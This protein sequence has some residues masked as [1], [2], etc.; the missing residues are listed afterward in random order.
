[1]IVFLVSL[2]LGLWT[3][4]TSSASLKLN[5]KKVLI[6][7]GGPSGLLTAHMLMAKS[8]ME[9]NPLYSVDIHEAG[10]SPADQLP[11]PR[12]YSLGLNI[13]GQTAVMYFDSKRSEG[14]FDRLKLEGVLSDSFFLHIGK[15]KFHIRK[16]SSAK[17]TG[18]DGDVAPPPTL[19]LPRNGLC[20]G[21]LEN[22]QQNYQ[23]PEDKAR[24]NIFYGSKVTAVDLTSN[25]ATVTPYTRDTRDTTESGTE[26]TERIEQ[27]SESHFDLIIGADGVSSAVRT[28][29]QEQTDLQVQ[30]AVLPGAFKVMTLPFPQDCSLDQSSVHALESTAK[31][32]AGFGLFLIPAPPNKAASNNTVCALLAWRKEEVPE[33]LKG[34]Q[35]EGAED[36]DTEKV[37]KAIHK[38]YPQLGYVPDEAIAQLA[39][40]RP[41]VAKTVRCSAYHSSTGNALI[42]GDAAHSTGGTLGQGANSA[43]L[44]VVALDRCLE[45]VEN[46]EKAGKGELR[47]G[48]SSALREFSETQ[49]KEGRA[50]WTLLQVQPKTLGLPW[51]PLYQL[52]QFKRSFLRLL[53]K[54]IVG[55][56]LFLL[57]SFGSRNLAEKA[58]NWQPAQAPTQQVLSQTL[59]PFSEIVRDNI[60]WVRKAM[61]KIGEPL[62]AM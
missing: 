38:D 11:G 7:G 37:R 55:N 35:L 52:A 53:Y 6:A 21:L 16:P 45:K 28:A 56:V 33:V 27:S 61:Q 1:M 42:L 18:K 50:L 54:N 30:E 58:R 32:R 34:A 20:L 19:L 2:F 23:Q 59:Q 46:K 25:T 8:D 12:T 43:L 47:E 15:N 17:Q 48:L 4:G 3:L 24:L 51:G 14:L 9:G 49:V 10:A 36:A 22:L 29:M 40:Q 62:E 39:R 13:R 26:R 44:D 57:L 31:D 5:L 60:F 41:S